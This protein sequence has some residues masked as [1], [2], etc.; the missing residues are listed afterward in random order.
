MVKDSILVYFSYETLL[1]NNNILFSS[2]LRYNMSSKNNF[3]LTNVKA[4]KVLYENRYCNQEGFSILACGGCSYKNKKD[5]N[6]VLDVKI[7]SFEVT[8]FPFMEKRHY[9]LKLTTIKSEIFGIA[10]SYVQY[11][12]LGSSRKSVEIFSEKT[13]TWKHQY[14]KFEERFY[15]CLC[16]FMSKVYIIGGYIKSKKTSISSCY[17]YNIKNNKRYKI[18]D[19]NQS[20]YG[21][22]STVFEGKIVIT[23]GFSKSENRQLKSVEAYDYYENKWTYLPDMIYERKSHAVVNIGN[24][25]FVIGGRTTSSCEVFDSFSRKFLIIKSYMKTTVLEKFYTEA[26]S[27]G[28]NIV[29]FHHCRGLK[30]VIY[31]YDVNKCKWSEVD[32][33]YT[34]TFVVQCCI[35]HFVQ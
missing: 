5:L 28:E 8:E 19:L 27:V 14:I 15:F 21:A 11:K 2:I 10:D 29:V 18:A 23:G 3:S 35:N 6:Q 26:F 12:K 30:T 13:K 31:V 9:L 34:K 4:V 22:A 32:C 1:K 17:T 20:R 24:K 7:P 33:S 16:S 25:L